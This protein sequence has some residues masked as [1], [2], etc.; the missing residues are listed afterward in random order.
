M[1]EVW[2]PKAECLGEAGFGPSDNPD[3]ALQ[4][5]DPKKTSALKRPRFGRYRM[6]AS[7]GDSRTPVSRRWP[8]LMTKVASSIGGDT[9]RSGS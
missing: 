3:T 2:L 1:S 5:P 6:L 8:C 4:G 7:R 9:A